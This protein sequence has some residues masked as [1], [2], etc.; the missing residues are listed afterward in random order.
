[1][2]SQLA[3]TRPLVTDEVGLEKKMVEMGIWREYY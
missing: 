3:D 2:G 1:M